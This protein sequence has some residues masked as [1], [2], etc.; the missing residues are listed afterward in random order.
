MGGDYGSGI[1]LDQEDGGEGAE[2]EE[3]EE[4][5]VGDDMENNE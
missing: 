4:A 3:E 5:K 1:P 2:G